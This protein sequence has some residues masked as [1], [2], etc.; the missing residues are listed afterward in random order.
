[1]R[2]VAE[3]KEMLS[4][5]H[6]EDLVDRSFGDAE[7]YWYLGDKEMAVGYYGKSGYSVSVLREDGSEKY[8]EFVADDASALR[9]TGATSKT[10]YN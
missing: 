10:N 7:V 6:R 4:K 1:M 3:A 8:D 9:Y 2:T 5:C